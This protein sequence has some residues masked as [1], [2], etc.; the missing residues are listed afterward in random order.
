MNSLLN[1]LTVL[2]VRKEKEPERCHGEPI[3][4]I[5]GGVAPVGS[6]GFRQY[7]F[8]AVYL[9]QPLSPVQNYTEIFNGVIPFKDLC[10]RR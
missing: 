8:T 6:R 9:S 2:H 3:E 1:I 7:F 10:M 5:G 4:R